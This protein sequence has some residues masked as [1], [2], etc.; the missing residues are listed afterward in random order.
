M[1]NKIDITARSFNYEI[2]MKVKHKKFGVGIIEKIEPEGDDFKLDIR[3]EKSGF[4]RLM[5]NFTPLEVIE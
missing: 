5:A 4:K 3:F 2:G 1:P